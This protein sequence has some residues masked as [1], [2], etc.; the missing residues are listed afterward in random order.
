[1]PTWTVYTHW[2]SMT[3]C[4]TSCEYLIHLLGLGMNLHL[5]VLPAKHQLV[6]NLV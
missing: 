1:M 4:C 5:V 6:W 2:L 3:A